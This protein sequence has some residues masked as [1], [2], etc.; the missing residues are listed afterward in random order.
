MCCCEYDIIKFSINNKD[1]NIRLSDIS[2]TSETIQTTIDPILLKSYHKNTVISFTIFGII[3][4]LFNLACWIATI[5]KAIADRKKI[6]KRNLERQKAKRFKL[7]S[8][9]NSVMKD[10]VESE[11]P[12]LIFP[13]IVDN[14]IHSNKVNHNDATSTPE[15][16]T[17]HFS[18]YSNL[19]HS[20]SM[21]RLTGEVSTPNSSGNVDYQS[22][23]KDNLVTYINQRV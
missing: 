6:K 2:K 16:P 8:H 7:E 12:K 23:E 20:G 19:R 13:T 9:R 10:L 18:K 1:V 22:N 15:S 17:H 5:I 21:K 14:V 11:P 4:G 3:F